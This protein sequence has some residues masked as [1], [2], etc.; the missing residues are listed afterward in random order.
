M[1]ILHLI[2]RLEEIVDRSPHVFG[3]VILDPQ[4]L[5]DLVDRMRIAV[6]E[7]V[8]E[9]ERRLADPGRAPAALAAGARP[10]GSDGRPREA[11]S[12]ASGSGGDATEARQRAAAITQEAVEQARAIRREADQYSMEV[13][14]RLEDELGSLLSQV[15]RGIETLER[16]GVRTPPP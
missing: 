11:L 10:G 13:L 1:D 7:S 12:L 8:R 4:E 3:R 14:G 16:E 9:A 6:P 5:L 2:D 15:R